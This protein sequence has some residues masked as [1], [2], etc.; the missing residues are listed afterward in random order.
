MMKVRK[1]TLAAGRFLPE[2]DIERSARVCVEGTRI[3]EDLFGGASA[4]GAI[5]RVG[6]ERYK[7]IGILQ[8]R[9]MSLGMDMDD[10]VEIPVAAAL[11]LF[12]TA[13]LFSH[14]FPL[15]SFR[16]VVF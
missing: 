11:A 5:L 13:A 12:C 4:L 3:Q 16:S 7:V 6:G 15:P 9:G 8:P 2:G 14:S 10:V 1:S